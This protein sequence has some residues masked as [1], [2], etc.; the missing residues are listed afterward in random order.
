MKSLNFWSETEGRITFHNP[1]RARECFLS[2]E[3]RSSFYD[4]EDLDDVTETIIET[5]L[6]CKDGSSLVMTADG[7]PDFQY[8]GDSTWISDEYFTEASGKISIKIEIWGWD[9]LYINETE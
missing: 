4:F 7:F 3:Y 1:E 6:I 9:N 5:F 2:E 8:D